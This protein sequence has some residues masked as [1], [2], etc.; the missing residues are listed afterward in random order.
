MSE[1]GESNA[2]VKG[3]QIDTKGEL[4]TMMNYGLSQCELSAHMALV[5]VLSY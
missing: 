2:I 5:F 1:S 3:I 4:S